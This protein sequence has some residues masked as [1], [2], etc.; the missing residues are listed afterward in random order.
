MKFVLLD[1][2]LNLRLAKCDDMCHQ[3][4]MFTSSTTAKQRWATVGLRPDAASLQ[5]Q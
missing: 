1:K 4:S 2:G 3:T 5:K